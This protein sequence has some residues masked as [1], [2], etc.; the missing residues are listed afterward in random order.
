MKAITLILAL[1]F[2]IAGITTPALAGIAPSATIRIDKRQLT[3]VF[4]SFRVHRQGKSAIL[5]WTV[6]SNDVASFIIQ[7]SYDGTYFD[8]LDEVGVSP[9]HWNKYKD[10]T[11]PGFIYYRIIAVMNDGSLE[12]S[13]VEMVDIVVHR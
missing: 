3:D 10:N 2:L 9:N 5:N 12:Y 7:R 1:L 6:L 13:P 4:G 8:N 11:D